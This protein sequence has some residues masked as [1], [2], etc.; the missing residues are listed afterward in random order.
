MTTTK[1]DDKDDNNDKDDKGDN[2]K[3][4]NNVHIL[5]PTFLDCRNCGE[6]LTAPARSFLKFCCFSRLVQ[7]AIH[8]EASSGQIGLMINTQL[9]CSV[10]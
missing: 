5:D 8:T 3:I 10:V 1:K 4:S 9:F 2:D 6:L 7:I